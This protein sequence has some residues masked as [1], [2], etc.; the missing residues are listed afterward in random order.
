MMLLKYNLYENNDFAS[1]GKEMDMIKSYI[2]LQQL[3]SDYPLQIQI[4]C[5]KEIYDKEIPSF[6]L[7]TLIENGIKHGNLKDPTKPMLLKIW[8]ENALIHI[9]S[10]NQ[11][12]DKYK[13][14]SSG[15]GLSNLKRRLNLLYSNQ[16]VFEVNQTPESVSYTH[17]TL[18]TIC[19]V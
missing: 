9:S 15:I 12:I 3:R 7:Q 5:D 18:P 1:L 4:H 2:E 8:E 10:V 19:S 17:L 13:D 11:Y 6:V 14:K 16:C